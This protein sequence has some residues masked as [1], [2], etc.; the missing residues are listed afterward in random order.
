LFRYISAL[1]N[2]ITVLESILASS[3]ERAAADR[4]ALVMLQRENGN[5]K[6]LSE[7]R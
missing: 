7:H 2:R 4:N 6:V 3:K 1:L 5:L